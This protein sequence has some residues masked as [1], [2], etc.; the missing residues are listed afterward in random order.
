M[1]ARQFWGIVFLFM[2][3]I[4]LGYW[5]GS[6]YWSPRSHHSVIMEGV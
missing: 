3:G 5:L 6:W 1:T 2:L 4:S